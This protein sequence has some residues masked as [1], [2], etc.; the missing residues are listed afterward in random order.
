MMSCPTT[1]FARW[2]ARMG[3]RLGRKRPLFKSEGAAMIGY[4]GKNAG[5]EL[6][7]A[8]ELPITVALACAA[9]E[10]GLDP[11]R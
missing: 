7:H 5:T 2:R 1:P 8:E 6:D 10:A 4:H 11:I 9:I 3:E